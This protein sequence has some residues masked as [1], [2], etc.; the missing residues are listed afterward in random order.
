MSRI[1]FPVFLM[2][3]LIGLSPALAQ[4]YQTIQVAPNIWITTTKNGLGKSWIT[5]KSHIGVFTTA[6]LDYHYKIACEFMNNC[7]KNEQR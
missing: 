5:E 3:F 6:P 4:T 2:Q 7:W 1:I